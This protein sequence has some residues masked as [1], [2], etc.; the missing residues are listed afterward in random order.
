M[1]ET[2]MAVLERELAEARE[3]LIGRVDR[4]DALSDLRYRATTH[5]ERTGSEPDTFAILLDAAPD[6]I[7]RAE[8][9]A[10][11]RRITTDEETPR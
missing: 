9:L 6:E 4:L 11:S 5:R 1:S 3:E 10:L 8:L 2:F 7:G